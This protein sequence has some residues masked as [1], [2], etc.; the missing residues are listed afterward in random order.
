MTTFNSLNHLKTDLKTILLFRCLFFGCFENLRTE[1]EHLFN[2]MCPVKVLILIDVFF[3][4]V[5]RMKI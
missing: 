5:G 1:R 4:V 3:V 2:Q